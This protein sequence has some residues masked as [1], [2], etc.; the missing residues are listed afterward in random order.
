MSKLAV[1]GGEP[2]IK[3]ELPFYKSI[4]EDEKKAVQ[5]V[6]DSG[7]LSGFYGSW[8]DEFYGGPR[9]REFEEAWCARFNVAHAISVNS[10]TSGLYSAMG[11][12]GISPGDEVIVPPFTMSAT[13]MA[14]LVY[15][16]I[17]VFVDIEENTFCLDP[18]LVKQA[19]TPRTKA[20]I[21]VNLF[22]HPA[23]LSVLRQ[24]ADQKNIYL[25][26]DN[27]QAPLAKENGKYAG[28]VGHIGVFSLNYHKHIHTGEGGVC[29]TNDDGLAQ[30]LQLIRNHGENVVEAIGMKDIKNMI[31]FNYRMTELTAAIGLVQLKKI[32][33]HVD[34][35]VKIGTSLSEKLK[36]L[37]GIK[38][39]N[40]RQH[41]S[42]VYYVWASRF[43]SKAIGVVRDTFSRAL[44][45][46]GFPHFNGYVKPLY[47]LP[48]FKQLKAI[49]SAGFPFN[50]STIRYM[51]GMCPVSERMFAEELICF[52]PCMY[53]LNDELIDNLV[54]AF[55]KVHKHYHELV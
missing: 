21:A 39:P 17:P 3:T 35:R 42:H 53:D 50:Q 43:D 14:P 49:G 23:S 32:D 30:R 47:N 46:E 2:T 22:G 10:A 7:C 24:I 29:V 31:G 27:A 8:C 54:D 34:C 11:A 16:G 36:H 33:A 5:D 15:G 19:I 51:P 9:V 52:E 48:V 20:I 4:G 38:A 18:E 12:I 25:I 55:S 44:S 40:V 6:M 45:A 37:E 1:F 28:T 13:A 41:C 26:E